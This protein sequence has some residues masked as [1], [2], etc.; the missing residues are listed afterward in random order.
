M[1]GQSSAYSNSVRS[2]AEV[3]RCL[4][5]LAADALTDEGDNVMAVELLW[6]PSE[7]GNTISKRELIQDY[8]ELINF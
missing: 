4:Q 5:G 6:T 7:R 1:K 3:K 8:P 2:L